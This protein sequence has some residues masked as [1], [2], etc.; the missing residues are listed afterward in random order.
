MFLG[1]KIRTFIY[2]ASDLSKTLNLFNNKSCAIL[3]IG[4]TCRVTKKPLISIFR[5]SAAFHF[6][7]TKV[8]KEKGLFVNLVEK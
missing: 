6:S 4:I 2:I 3:L 7:L 1:A 8:T 5:T